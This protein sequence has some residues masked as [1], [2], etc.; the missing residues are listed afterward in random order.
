MYRNFRKTCT[1]GALNVKHIVIMFL[2]DQGF[3]RL[4]DKYLEFSQLSRNFRI[5]ISTRTTR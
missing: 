4:K 2:N 3:N 1:A 5:I